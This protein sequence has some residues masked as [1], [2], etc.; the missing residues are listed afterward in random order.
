[1]NRRQKQIEILQELQL[2][3]F[4]KNR[5]IIGKAERPSNTEAKKKWENIISGV[6]PLSF[7]YVFD[8]VDARTPYMHNIQLVTKDNYFRR[9]VKCKASLT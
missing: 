3:A 2:K 6:D 7:Y 9:C 8:V 4:F 1:M 5:E